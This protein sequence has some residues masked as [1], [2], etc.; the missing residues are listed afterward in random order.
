M[1][2]SRLTL[3]RK[4]DVAAL[5]PLLEPAHEGRRMDAH[6]RLIWSAFAGD[7]AASRDFLW[8]DMGRGQ[9]MVLSPRPPAA[10]ALFE[11]PEVKP[12]APELSPG[13]RL[14]FVL[15]AN[16]TRARKGAGRVDVVMDALKAVPR[17][18]RA[19]R[20]MEIAQKAGADWLAGQGARAGFRVLDC[21]VGAY[22]VRDLPGQ[23]R[24][25]PRFGVLDLEGVLEITD[26]QAFLA[27]LRQ[28][29][30]RAKAFG[31][32]LMLIRRA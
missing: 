13:D 19:A 12:F 26:A 6:H 30:G 28:G 3:D 11:S 2:L 10:S 8:R 25:R 24:R 22:D 15:R 18:E 7:P 27:R 17:P 5:G 32:G 31:C 23:G 29:F 14:A 21:H 1:Y 16:A 4:P 20:R 9:F